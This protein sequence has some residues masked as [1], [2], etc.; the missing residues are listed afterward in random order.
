MALIFN[1][2]IRRLFLGRGVWGA[3]FPGPWSI[4]VFKGT[5]PTAAELQSAWST[6]NANLLAHYL[7]A[8]WT[9]PG[10]SIFLQLTIP[11]SVNAVGDGAASWAVLWNSNI[12]LAA[13]QGA[14]LPSPN[15][16]IV[17]CT[18]SIGDGVIR[19]T[20]VNF[21]NGSP[22]VILDGSIGASTP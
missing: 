11:A 2:N 14:S 7:S 1:G 13:V 4:S 6:Y 9:Q 21:T 22:K 10:D 17:P 19:F 20:D 18:D 15:G 5:Q 3:F 8:N 16:L 12:S